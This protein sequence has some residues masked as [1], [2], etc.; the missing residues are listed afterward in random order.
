MCGP[1][2]AWDIQ[3]TLSRLP[4]ARSRR[5][6]GISRTGTP[7]PCTQTS[8]K[9]PWLLQ[10]SACMGPPDFGHTDRPPRPSCPP[11]AW[12]TILKPLPCGELS[13][14]H[15]PPPPTPRATLLGHPWRPTWPTKP[16]NG[17]KIAL[18][19]AATELRPATL[20]RPAGLVGHSPGL[21][22]ARRCWGCNHILGRG[23]REGCSEVL[24]GRSSRR[25]EL[26]WSQGCRCPQRR[27][28]WVLRANR[29]RHR[30]LHSR[31][32]CP[33]SAPTSWCVPVLPSLAEGGLASSG[34]CCQALRRALRLFGTYRRSDG[35]ARVPAGS[36][37]SAPCAGKELFISFLTSIL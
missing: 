35:K 2:A 26:E 37:A 13:K 5:W 12:G 18:Q 27:V 8:G 21:Q 9:S 17:C 31:K 34:L 3:Q 29:T 15:P 14:A 30:E 28:P 36:W 1:V 20:C 33:S 10:G 7:A 32:P 4:A 24:G 22:R 11:L 25:L 23:R 6:A 19:T 16:Q